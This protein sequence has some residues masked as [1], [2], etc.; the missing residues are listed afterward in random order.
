MDALLRDEEVCLQ[1]G[2]DVLVWRASSVSSTVF[3]SLVSFHALRVALISSP[4]MQEGGEFYEQPVPPGGN[5]PYLDSDGYYD[6]EGRGYVGDD[7]GDEAIVPAPQPKP[8]KTTWW[9]S[10]SSG[11]ESSRQKS[12]AVPSDLPSDAAVEW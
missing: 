7:W 4:L 5:D 10:K 6:T 8:S 3:T 9:G 12:K 1:D 11:R 2:S